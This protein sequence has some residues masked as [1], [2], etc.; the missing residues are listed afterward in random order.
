MGA[1]PGSLGA[2]GFTRATVLVDSALADRENMVTGANLDGF[3]LRGVDVARDILAHGAG[4]ADLRTVEAGE[5]CPNCDALLEVFKALE[6]GHI[7]KLGTRYSQPLS[8][9]VLTASGAEVPIF[10]GS[11]GIGIGRIM[12]A[13]IEQHHDPDG[14]I[15]PF[16]I[17]PYH[18]HV[19][20]LGADADLLALADEVVQTLTTA[21]LDVLYDDRD[22]RAGVKFKD[23][24][25]LGMPLRIAVGKKGVA[26]RTV[27]WKPR[28]AD[29]VE[30][31]ALADLPDHL[32]KLTDIRGKIAQT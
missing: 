4:L 28:H 22:A 2:V 17:A 15:W 8:A 5:G 11:Y 6:L 25:L 3:H 24:D 9:H 1:H 18:A 31:V 29:A 26:A 16:S 19:L 21:G 30:I 14:I 20:T 23:G 32:R 10:M 13:S 7:F 12:A 27:E